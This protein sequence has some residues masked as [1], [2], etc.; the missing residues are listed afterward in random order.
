MYCKPQNSVIKLEFFLS[1]VGLKESS[2]VLWLKQ[3][4]NLQI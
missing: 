1:H 4:F 3:E 2:D